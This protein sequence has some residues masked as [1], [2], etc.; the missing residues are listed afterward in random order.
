MSLLSRGMVLNA[1]AIGLGLI[2]A[3]KVSGAPMQ[4]RFWAISVGA[5]LVL[6]ACS[7]VVVN[8]LRAPDLPPGDPAIG[9]FS[10]VVEANRAVRNLFI[11]R[12]VGMEGLLAVSSYPNLGWDL[13]TQAWKE[14][15]EYKLGFYDSTF[16]DSWAAI[17]D[18]T[19]FHYIT[20][21][22]IVA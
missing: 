9:V 20:V 16:I 3:L 12:W 4:P 6:F 14:V 18:R 19:R 7:V 2:R 11:D 13:W 21:P 22:G 17:V 8:Y 10:D 15:F 1:S 5:F